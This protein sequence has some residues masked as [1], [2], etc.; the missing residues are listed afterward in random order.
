MPVDAVPDALGRVVGR[1]LD[2][3]RPL[4]RFHEW[5]RRS[6]GDSLGLTLQGNGN[7][8]PGKEPAR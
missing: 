7:G 6:E 8:R 3:R 1:Y 5:V 4:E 2:E